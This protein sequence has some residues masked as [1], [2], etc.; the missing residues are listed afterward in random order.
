MSVNNFSFHFL[1]GRKEITSIAFGSDGEKFA[2]SSLDKSVAIY[3]FLKKTP[4][5]RRSLFNF[6]F[7]IYDL[8]YS[9]KNMLAV[10]GNSKQAVVQEAVLLN[11]YDEKYIAHQSTIRSVHFSNSGNKFITASDDKCIKM[12][13]LGQRN[14]LGSFTG[15]TNWIRCA[16]FSPSNKMIASCS[17]DKTVKVFDV[18]S[19]QMIHSF[20]DV[21]GYGN[22]LTWHP[23]DNSIAIAQENGRV[24]IYDLAQRKLVQYYRIYDG[25]VKCLDFHP[26]GNYLV[27]GDEKGLTKILDLIEGRD[28]FTLKGHND[29]VTA[30]KFNKDGKYFVTGSKDRH[31]MIFESNLSS[32]QS[33]LASMTSEHAEDKENK[34]DEGVLVDI[35]KSVNYN[36]LNNDEVNV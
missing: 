36:Y 6:D 12:F 7:E 35:R 11:G 2:V 19:G 20:K 24:K 31:V 14:F 1:D 30:I 8:D 9:V 26:S 27:T 29:A 21:N 34:R 4:D 18:Q 5:A 10:V 13:R 17:E 25:A 3:S 33:S 16:R 28:I 15:H 22:Q 23:D 32:N